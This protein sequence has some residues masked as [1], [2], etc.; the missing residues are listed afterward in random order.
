MRNIPQK[1][2]TFSMARRSSRRLLFNAIGKGQT[3]ESRSVNLRPSVLQGS[4]ARTQT[5]EKG[6]SPNDLHD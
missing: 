6:G 4:L 2:R 5:I 1:P 3:D